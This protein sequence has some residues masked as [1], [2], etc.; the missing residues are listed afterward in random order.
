[1]SIQ[2]AFV[3][4][5]AA[6]AAGLVRKG[7]SWLMNAGCT[8]PR[9]V[10]AFLAHALPVAMAEGTVDTS[11]RVAMSKE[12]WW[13]SHLR[14]NELA[15]GHATS[16]SWFGAGLGAFLGATAT[17][18]IAGAVHRILSKPITQVLAHGTLNEAKEV[19]FNTTTTAVVREGGLRTETIVGAVAI[20]GLLGAAAGY[21]W[22]NKTHRALG[23]TVGAQ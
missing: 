6:A 23:T 7:Q 20:G 15:G 8:D 3:R 18:T 1:M 16:D 22:R 13:R 10:K 5:D 19:V 14:A 17:G 9:R 21:A 12:E 4:R 11:I 2:A